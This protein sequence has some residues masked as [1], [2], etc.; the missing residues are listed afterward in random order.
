MV[1]RRG[2]RGFQT[3]SGGCSE[4]KLSKKECKVLLSHFLRHKAEVE[5]ELTLMSEFVRVGEDVLHRKQAERV[6]KEWRERRII[7]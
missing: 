6:M 1:Q 7:N 2:L 3:P 5:A 4:V